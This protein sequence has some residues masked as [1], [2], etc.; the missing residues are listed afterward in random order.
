MS[1]EE[2]NKLDDIIER[3]KRMHSAIAQ[4]G[5]EIQELRKAVV[6]LQQGKK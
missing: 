5:G 6:A 4:M 1:Q 2:L 3:L